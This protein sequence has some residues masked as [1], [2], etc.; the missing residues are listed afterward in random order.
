MIAA[1]LLAAGQST[2]M[3]GTNKLL[4]PFQGR[5]L[6]ERMVETVTGSA[7]GATVVVLGYEAEQVRPLVERSGVTVA[8]NP[9]FAEGMA[10]SIRVGLAACPPGA[11]GY[12]VCLTDMP[13]L[14]AED[15]DRLVAAFAG[16]PAAK[17]ILLAGHGERRG[18]PVLFAA[19]YRDDVALAQGPIGG[20]KGI[21]KRHPD[22]VLTVD[23]GNDHA[24]WDID[25]PED[26]R[27]L[28]AAHG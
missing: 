27:R 22:R 1:I 5:T 24:V 12:M 26:Y 18:N 13:L 21:V 20:C 6:V 10:G 4:L 9:E 11:D 8:V 17:D 15:L 25:T 28:V 2:R 23:L 19:R 3:G 16:R 7:V 14:R